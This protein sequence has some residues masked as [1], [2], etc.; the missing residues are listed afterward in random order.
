MGPFFVRGIRANCHDSVIS[1]D[2]MIIARGHQPGRGPKGVIMAYLRR[3]KNSRYWHVVFHVA[4]Q[5]REWSTR[6][7]NHGIEK[8]ILKK[9]EYDRLIGQDTRPTQTPVAT[10]LQEFAIRLRL[11][12]GRTRKK[13]PQTDFYRLATWFGPVCEALE[14]NPQELGRSCPK[15]GR[16][17]RRD[18]ARYVAPLNV[19]IV[20][21]ITTDMVASWLT[22]LAVR[23]SLHGKTVNEY[24]EV[25]SRFLSWAMRRGVRMPRNENPVRGVDHFRIEQKP[26][27]FLTLEQ[28]D[29]QLEVLKPEPMFRCMVAVLIYAGIRL[30]ELLWLTKSDVD[31]DRGYIL[32]RRKSVLGRRWMPKTGQDR[33]VPISTT[34]RRFL[35]AY[36]SR[37]GL[38]WY[39]TTPM[40]SQWDSDGFGAS[41][42]RLNRPAGLRWTALDFRHTF[43]S[44]LAMKGE[45][46]FKI[47][48]LLG[49]GPEVCRRHYAALLPESLVAAVEFHAT[50]STPEERM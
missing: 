32:V 10:L 40:G 1:M 44:H 42:R 8:R 31:L 11:Q 49:N 3:P 24:R 33:S 34:L 7:A 22:T 36:E 4:G 26:I 21:E 14:V 12:T 47:S 25:L 20:E 13:G 50:G 48:K 18:D 16:R 2:T 29:Q 23:R 37:S 17:I 15:Q 41:L 9:W 46:L 5:R 43:G 30:G 6:S 35:D 45:T 38:P 39:F 27:R 19:A 28:L